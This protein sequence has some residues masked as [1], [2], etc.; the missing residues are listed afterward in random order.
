DLL[1]RLK[2][3]ATGQFPFGHLDLGA[4]ISRGR[5]RMGDE[6][7]SLYRKDEILRSLP[8]PSLGRGDAGQIVERG[9]DLER[10]KTAI[11]PVLGHR[12]A[13]AS[14]RDHKKFLMLRQQNGAVRLL[15]RLRLYGGA[16]A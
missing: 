2:M 10:G 4:F 1:A 13:A 14:N 12:P 6:L 9:I 8:P 7:P 3:A 16:G 5:L 15:D 11:V